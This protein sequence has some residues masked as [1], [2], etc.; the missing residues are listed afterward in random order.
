MREH[1]KE[2]DEDKRACRD[3]LKDCRGQMTA[4]VVV[5]ASRLGDG[6]PNAHP[7]RAHHGEHEDCLQKPTEA[8]PAANKSNPEREGQNAFVQKHGDEHF[9]D[10]WHVVL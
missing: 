8:R 5:I 2:G 10:A 3:A 4:D 1:F 7:D 6:D 9:E